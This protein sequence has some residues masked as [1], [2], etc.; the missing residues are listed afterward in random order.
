VKENQIRELIPFRVHHI[1]CFHG[2]SGK[3][4][5]EKFIEQMNYL[6]ILFLS[7]PDTMLEIISRPD[8]IC[9]SCPNLTDTGCSLGNCGNPEER[10][11]LRDKEVMDLLGLSEG[12]IISVHDAFKLAESR[13]SPEKLIEICSQC[14]WLSRS[15]C[16]E[17]ISKDFW[18]LD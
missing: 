12:Q 3:G 8:Y 4:Y 14:D 5:N 15:S 13:I 10:I 6:K 16:A 17:N 7:N 18:S 11:H 9:D 1:L 2:Y